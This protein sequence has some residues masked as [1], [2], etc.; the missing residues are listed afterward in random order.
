[1]A[2]KANPVNRSKWMSGSRSLTT[3]EV[4]RTECQLTVMKTSTQLSS[5]YYRYLPQD[6]PRSKLHRSRKSL[7]IWFADLTWSITNLQQRRSQLR[8]WIQVSTK[9]EEEVRVISR[10][11]HPLEELRTAK[12]SILTEMAV[13]RRSQGKQCTIMMVQLMKFKGR[14]SSMD[15]RSKHHKQTDQIIPHL[16]AWIRSLQIRVMVANTRFFRVE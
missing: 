11:S 7:V 1:M 12:A 16:S 14:K 8:S 15:L 13:Q 9:T 4:A 2:T 5:S 10:S 6:V 3:G